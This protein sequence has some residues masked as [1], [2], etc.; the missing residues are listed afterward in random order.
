MIVEKALTATLNERK[1]RALDFVAITEFSFFMRTPR[2]E[3]RPRQFS[4]VYIFSG[5]LK[6]SGCNNDDDD[7]VE[8]QTS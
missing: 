5:Y 6:I 8:I 7:D 3:K 4:T 1:F 2:N